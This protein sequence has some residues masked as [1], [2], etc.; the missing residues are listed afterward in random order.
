MN[1]PPSVPAHTVRY[2]GPGETCLDAQA[3]DLI[4][5]ATDNP[6]ARVIRFGER[7]RCHGDDRV[8]AKVTHAMV[9]LG[10]GSVVQM[11]GG[12]GTVTPLA[13]YK[14]LSYAVVNTTFTS[15]GQLQA[16]CEVA[17]WYTG[18]EYG[19]PSV[20]SDAIYMLT[21]IPI[22]LTIGQSVVCSAMA[23]AT[24]RPLGLIP[25][26]VDIAVLPSDLAQ[27]YEVRLP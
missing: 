4:L 27:W 20:V 24:Q 6:F 26:K 18:I 11:I 21:G 15:L 23:T 5:V 3:A 9:S 13:D 1:H 16:A 14:H 8:F 17:R 7:L 2:F 10:D 19:W 12:G 25:A 22:A